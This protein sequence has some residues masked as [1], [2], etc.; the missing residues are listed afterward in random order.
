MKKS[1]NVVRLKPK[2]AS[3]RKV[4]HSDNGS[5]ISDMTSSTDR[6]TA[7][8]CQ[9]SPKPKR[10]HSPSMALMP[11]PSVSASSTAASITVSMR[12]SRVRATA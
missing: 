5:P 4:L 2:R 12:P 8:P 9:G 3:S 6:I 7:A 11:P 10:R 1:A